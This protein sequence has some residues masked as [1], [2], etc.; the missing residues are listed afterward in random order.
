MVCDAPRKVIIDGFLASEEAMGP[1]TKL[2]SKM[3]HV[4]RHVDA[5]HNAPELYFNPSIHHLQLP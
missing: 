1:P 4:S 5:P 2:T 3:S